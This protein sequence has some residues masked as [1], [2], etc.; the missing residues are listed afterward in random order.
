MS[1]TSSGRKRTET[2]AMALTRRQRRRQ[3]VASARNLPAK[4]TRPRAELAAEVSVAEA[5]LVEAPAVKPVER[6]ATQPAAPGAAEDGGTHANHANHANIDTPEA[7]KEGGT[8]PTG[9]GENGGGAHT[10]GAAEEDASVATTHGLAERPLGGEAPTPRPGVTTSSHKHPTLALMAE[11]AARGS[12]TGPLPAAPARASAPTPSALAP[13]ATPA[14]AGAKAATARAE[15]ETPRG[16]PPG[17]ETHPLRAVR[18][19]PMEVERPRLEGGA[20][21][22]EAPPAASLSARHGHQPFPAPDLLVMTM[23][24]HAALAAIAAILG[25]LLML[26][27][28][29][30]GL[31]WLACATLAG[32]S[33]G[34]AYLL[35]Q[36]PATRRLAG[37]TLICAQVGMFAWAMELIGP[38]A[39][40]LALAPALAVL[41]ARMVSWRA[42]MGQTVAMLAAYLL[43]LWMTRALGL[44]PLVAVRRPGV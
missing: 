4:A 7:A 10:T 38:R 6:V 42:A 37:M 16:R 44:A 35:E 20:S 39:T 33:G 9:A 19:E 5:V 30:I 23:G 2:R 24:G 29:W 12:G 27:G 8:P 13:S 26:G 18:R 25:A 1:R 31:A 17:A 11:I 32:C 22:T 41:A 40:L 3:S 43:F 28:A 21:G 15:P 14:P 34:L 36:Q